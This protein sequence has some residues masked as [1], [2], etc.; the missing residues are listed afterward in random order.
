MK[1]L[2]KAALIVLS[3]S[4]CYPAAMAQFVAGAGSPVNTACVSRPL[5]VGVGNFHL[6]GKL[7]LVVTCDSSGNA[8]AAKVFPGAGNGAFNAPNSTPAVT[9]IFPSSAV[10]ADFNLDGIP[11]LAVVN[12]TDATVSVYTGDGAG[13]FTLQATLGQSDG[14]GTN[15]VFV[16]AADVNGDGIPDLLVVNQADGSVTV[17]YTNINE[18]GG[19][20][21]FSTTLFTSGSNPAWVTVGD[22]NGD[23]SPDVAVA[24]NGSG[25]VDI[26]LNDND[27][28]FNS[29]NP[30]SAGSNPSSIVAGDF[31][32]D[33]ILDLA[34]TNGGSGGSTVT[35]LLGGGGGTF[36]IAVPYSGAGTSPYAM[37]IGD[38]D[39][40]GNL[41]LAI[42]DNFAGSAT[43]AV[44][45]GDGS[46]VFNPAAGS[47][48]TISGQQA[49]SIAAG[50]FNG[51]A[52]LD[53]AITTTAG[54]NILLNTALRGNPSALL[55]TGSSDPAA[56]APPGA[57]D[58]ISAK[59]GAAAT[60][61][62]SPT[63]SWISVTPTT[64]ST[65]SPQTLTVSTNPTGLSAGIHF[66]EVD[67]TAAGHFGATI[68]VTLDVIGPSG[69][70]LPAA[71]SPFDTGGQ[72]SDVVVAADFNNDGIL[73]LAVGN[74]TSSSITIFFGDGSGGFTSSPEQDIFPEVA[75]F[76]L[77]AGD[78]NNDGNID[79]AFTDGSNPFV[80]VFEGD[81][82]G[83]FFPFFS[84]PVPSGASPASLTVGDFNG[85]G[86]L[87][88]AFSNTTLLLGDGQGNFAPAP[89][90]GVQNGTAGAAFV[91]SGDFNS[92][93]LPDIAV[94]NQTNNNLSIFLNNGAGGFTA[95]SG[96]PYPTGAAPQGLA[97]GDFNLDGKLDLVTA[98]ST[99]GTV[100]VFLGDGAGGFSAAAGSPFTAVDANF[101]LAADINGD[102]FPDI[103]SLGSGGSVTILLGNGAGGFT[104]SP[105]GIISGGNGPF[106]AVAAD[107]NGDGLTDLALSDYV[108]NNLT[109]LL[110]APAPTQNTLSTTAPAS[111]PAGTQIPLTATLA[112]TGP[113]FQVP[114]GMVTFFEGEATIGT[115][116]LA[117]GAATYSSS[118]PVGNHT[119]SAFYGGDL[120]DLN[121][122]SNSVS[123]TVTPG[124]AASIT[125]VSGNT[126]TTTV[127][128]QFESALQAMVTDAFSNPVPNA[129]V[130]FTSPVSG[131]G[132][133]FPGAVTAVMVMTNSSGIAIAPAFTANQIAGGPYH[134]SASVTGVVTQALFN[135]T[136][137]P[138]P[139]ASIAVASGQNQSAAINSAF[140]N[141]FVVSVQDNFGNFITG[142]TVTF[143]APS[144]G[145]SGAFSRG[146][147]A[148][149]VTNLAGL[150]AAPTFTANGIL[151]SYQLTAT[152]NGIE[153]PAIF[154]LSNILGMV[155]AAP[156]NLAFSVTL[157]SAL[158]ASQALQITAA[159]PVAFN[160]A[161]ATSS[162][163]NWLAAAPGSGTTPS[164]V[165]VS[166]LSAA[167]SLAPGVYNG[168]VTV[169]SATN[170]MIVPVT[171]TVL[172]PFDQLSGSLSFAYA[173][174]NPPP[175]QTVA[176]SSGNRA[177]PF[178]VSVPPSASWL[179]VTLMSAISSASRIS[180]SP[181]GVN[182]L[183]GTTPAT[184]TV[185][186][187]PSS[188]APG[189]YSAAITISSP[190]ASNSPLTIPVSLEVLAVTTASPSSL[191]F[192]ASAGQN[193]TAPQSISIG[194]T[195]GISFSAQASSSWIVVNPTSGVTPA[196]LSVQV[197]PTGLAT[198]SY[199]GSISISGA[200]ANSLS[201]PVSVTIQPALDVVAGSGDGAVYLM[202]TA[203][204]GVF[205]ADTPIVTN[206]SGSTFTAGVSGQGLVTTPT[207][208]TLPTVLHTSVDASTSAPGTYTGTLTLNIPDA[209]PATRTLTV[210]YTV[211]A[212]EP[213]QVMTQA[214]DLT[215]SVSA[216]APTAS[217][218]A[219]ASNLGSG[220]I[221]FSAT[222]DQS[223]IQVSPSTGATTLL[224]AAPIGIALDLTGFAP[225]TYH[226]HVTVSSSTNSVTLPVNVSVSGQTTGIALSQ[227]GL[228][229]NA[230]AGAPAPPPQGFVVLDT[231]VEPFT[232]QVSTSTT[233]GGGWLSAT[234][235]NGSTDTAPGVQVSVNATGLAAGTYYGQVQV[236][237]A[238]NPEQ[239]LTVVLNVAASGAL[240]RPSVLPSGLIFTAAAN[241]SNPASQT[242][243][244]QNPTANAINFVSTPIY[245]SGVNFFAYDPPLGT[246]APGQT[247]T[248]TVTAT[249]VTITRSLGAGVYRGQLNLGFV[250]YDSIQPVD[251]L[252]V[253]APAAVPAAKKPH[254]KTATTSQACTPSKLLPVFTILGSNFSVSAG[255]PAAIQ[256]SVVDDCANFV[257]SG[258]VLTTFSNGDPAISL[259]SLGGG[260]W[261]AT[262]VP[263]N[264]TGNAVITGSATK[265]VSN[266]LMLTG[267][268]QIMG[269]AQANTQ[270]PIVASGGVVN[271]ASF[272]KDSP[273]P[274]GALIAIFGSSLA[275]QQSSANVLPLPDQLGTTSV[276]IDGANVPLLYSSDGQVNGVVPFALQQ[277][278]THLLVVTKGN[279]ISVPEPVTIA[280]AQPAVFTVDGSGTGQGVV[281]GFLNGG[282]Q[283]L[284]DSTNPVSA[285]QY[286]VM[287]ATGL[288]AVTPPV[289]DGVAG[290]SS[291][292]STVA[293]PIS[294][295]IGGVKA[296]ITYAGLAPG[297]AS[298]YQLDAIVP[299]VTPGNSVPLVITV[300]GQDSPPVTIA[301]K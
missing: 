86:N 261:A 120:R 172:A 127:G 239:S 205:A 8:G 48:Y 238:A 295:T 232:F 198:G 20:S 278:V 126:Q 112:D 15:P 175:S 256:M 260:S 81:G 107:F 154:S 78:F 170:Q 188:L 42:A 267:S 165:N 58:I 203:T 290:P 54:A 178:T 255:F 160:L 245:T 228:T 5:A 181:L 189:S 40:D 31:N 74:Q 225:G 38:F 124:P 41:D 59:S 284:A 268:V 252:L 176:V 56:P 43:V 128:T 1:F 3:V 218:Q 84:T 46:G 233:S 266:A 22:F 91:V 216:T 73:D 166:V 286:I 6:S 162:G 174:G 191:S 97:V 204:P 47:P 64:G 277:N 139:P 283:V 137:Q 34:V 80:F 234:P 53:L 285:G 39:G 229:F 17:L 184:L 269:N 208:G 101:V 93:G 222:S 75:V 288:G 141:P 179:S 157:P 209:N 125:V 210:S 217:R 221:N 270:T 247:Q 257:T 167:L 9:G 96:S 123:V 230:A 301:V 85:D 226:G 14:I 113:G 102:G 11:D 274:P 187:D 35:I 207:S 147:T 289:T 129:T 62:A 130:T 282:A 90:V 296:T 240:I 108:G 144:S 140:S 190:Y 237:S 134:V 298:L 117:S 177:V 196:S 24:D 77:V 12:L 206:T 118:Y 173:S 136:N 192:A 241:G 105:G 121:S 156:T 158:P 142:V 161:V 55:F 145:P 265:T 68:P 155:A 132:G 95:A 133:T 13:G 297:F 2:A 83:D 236:V 291:P 280:S 7:D 4:I 254:S 23:G 200:G 249:P 148:T 65:A 87:D 150:A 248:I 212:P 67:V 25:T 159:G 89:S 60:F 211:S 110:G 227:T 195:S 152:V 223:W 57:L 18:G 197:N 300:D 271:A 82:M 275:D 100:S 183:S 193:P 253:V 235:A 115:G 103:V 29:P 149:A 104:P 263:R 19:L 164:T 214:P 202:P 276:T 163:G 243:S 242:I 37:V 251:V 61:T 66:G 76:A 30:F 262:W 28:G 88:I 219:V 143:T 138:G 244:I 98:N 292:L 49:T 171:L 215:F 52:R 281:L 26:F 264:P 111:V 135:L 122:F 119:F 70:V 258:S 116:A 294:L 92:D 79:L 33:G 63:Q 185:S 182:S 27:G 250:G 69:I 272:A 213:P 220:T 168:S 146:T 71:N 293:D 151:G 180:A 246:I 50:D 199:S 109:V 153:T 21:F 224:G 106:S 169:L 94:V 114:T 299:V 287:Y 32:G 231:G 194:G 51:D 279:A 10:V 72:G 259:K 186:V 131:A 45:L 36:P 273:V 99:D 44:L 201:I 16:T